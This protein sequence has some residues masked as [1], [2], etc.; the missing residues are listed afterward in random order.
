M[1]FFPDAWIF[2][3]RLPRPPFSFLSFSLIPSPRGLRQQESLNAPL[4]VWIL[5][6]PLHPPIF[7][8]GQIFHSVRDPFCAI[9]CFPFQG[10]GFE[11]V[12]VLFHCR[13]CFFSKVPMAL[14]DFFTDVLSGGFR[15]RYPLPFPSGRRKR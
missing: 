14:F 5:R 15:C 12:P 13:L 10:R 1:L 4:Q 8:L 3:L 11:G 7:S 6:F 2:P 9:L